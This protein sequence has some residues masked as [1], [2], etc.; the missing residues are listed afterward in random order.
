MGIQK[1]WPVS[2]RAEACKG[3]L[4]DLTQMA[5]MQKQCS[6]KS[7]TFYKL[8]RMEIKEYLSYQS[9]YYLLLILT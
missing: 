6:P 8:E 3:K 4:E 9:K 5:D 7:H 2:E 1:N